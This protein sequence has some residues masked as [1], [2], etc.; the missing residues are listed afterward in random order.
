MRPG[1]DLKGMRI[2]EF[3]TSR[4]E[5]TMLTRLPLAM[6]LPGTKLTRRDVRPKSGYRV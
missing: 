1:Q 4:F 3:D 5:S 6:L 2:F